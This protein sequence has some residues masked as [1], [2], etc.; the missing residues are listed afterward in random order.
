[1]EPARAARLHSASRRLAWG[2][3]I[4]DEGTTRFGIDGRVLRRERT[5][6]L[7][8]GSRHV[9]GDIARIDGRAQPP[10]SWLRLG[11]TL[12]ISTAGS[13]PCVHRPALL[14]SLARML[15][16]EPRAR[17]GR[18]VTRCQCPTA[19]IEM[20]MESTTAWWNATRMPGFFGLRLTA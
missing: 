16:V 2:D 7:V 19:T 12:G 4:G 18:G 5:R 3:R 11:L 14:H 17:R 1:M 20:V 10:R 8:G 9:Y 15:R 13:D 6:R